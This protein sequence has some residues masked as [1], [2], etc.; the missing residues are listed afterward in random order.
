MKPRAKATHTVLGTPRAISSSRNQ[1][2]A[3][4]LTKS[5]NADGA[6]RITAMAH[7]HALVGHTRNHVPN[8]A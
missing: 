8:P 6:R 3:H 1:I 2:G 4:A 5:Y 7:Y